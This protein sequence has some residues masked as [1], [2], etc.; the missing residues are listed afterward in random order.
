MVA[1][2]IGYTG[3]NE[4]GDVGVK[5]LVAGRGGDVHL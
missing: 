3:Q 2:V 1:M 5:L 4:A